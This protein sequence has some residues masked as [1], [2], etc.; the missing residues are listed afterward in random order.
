MRLSALKNKNARTL[1]GGEA[2]RVAIA[3][4]VAVEPEVLLLDEPT[5]NLDPN[6]TLRIEEMLQDIFRQ[7]QTTMIMATHDFSQGRRLAHR[8]GVMVKGEIMQTGKAEE[9]FDSP[10]NREIAEFVGVENIIPGKIISR[11]GDIATIG[12]DGQAIEA[13]SNQ[14][15]GEAVYVCIRPEEITL[16]P[17]RATSS[18]RNTFSGAITRLTISGSLAQVEVDCGFPLVSLVTKRSVEELDLKPGQPVYASFKATAV[19]VLKRD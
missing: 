6:S 15:I 10:S 3:R 5:A 16:S 19:H 17:A 7:Y 18:A 9:I 2:Q 12:L 13:V 8:I 11:E 14:S 1:S 4:A